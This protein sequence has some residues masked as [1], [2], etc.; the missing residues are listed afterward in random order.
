MIE[1]LEATLEKYNYLEQELTKPEVLGDVKKT[2]EYSK[3]VIVATE[4][5][6]SMKEN[7]RPTRAEVS[8]VANAVLDGTDAVMLSGETTVGKHP[9]ETVA[10]MAKICEV[11]EQYAEFDYISDIA[12][13]KTVSAAIAE[14]VVESSNRLGAK[15]ICAAT[16]SGS[17]AKLI[18]NFNT[19]F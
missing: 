2:R 19:I 10:A 8:D 5:L 1:R 18:S 9:V 13:V 3:F 15:L 14:S 6:E 4:M 16:M 12:K 7:L 17:T 11:T